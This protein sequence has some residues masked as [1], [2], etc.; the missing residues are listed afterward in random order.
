MELSRRY[1]SAGESSEA[2]WP[3]RPLAELARLE[4]YSAGS[5]SDEHGKKILPRLLLRRFYVGQVKAANSDAVFPISGTM[6]HGTFSAS[7]RAFMG[8][9]NMFNIADLSKKEP[10]H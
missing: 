5:G 7:E 6:M 3:Y 2:C 8:E 10:T 4:H 9:S 1:T